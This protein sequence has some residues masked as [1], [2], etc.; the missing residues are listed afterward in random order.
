M[1]VYFDP[2]WRPCQ[3][4]FATL[5]NKLFPKGFHS[6]QLSITVRRL[7]CVQSIYEHPNFKIYWHFP[8]RVMLSIRTHLNL[9]FNQLPLTQKPYGL[10]S[11]PI[12]IQLWSQRTTPLLFHKRL[13][14]EQFQPRAPDSPVL[15]TPREF[16]QPYQ[17]CATN[18]IFWFLNTLW[19]RFAWRA[20]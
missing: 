14:W 8:S 15:K 17:V 10:S 19:N 13:P 18:A 2:A 9:Y 6:H 16:D 7:A 4:G 20:N 5:R 3:S 11:A 12:R 1:K